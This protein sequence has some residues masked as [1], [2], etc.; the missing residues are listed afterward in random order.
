MK[1]LGLLTHW[2]AARRVSVPLV[3]VRTPDP[4][5]SMAAL[6]SVFNGAPPPLLLWDICGGMRGINDPG[7]EA[8]QAVLPPADESFGGDTGALTAN[9]V[10]ALILAGKLPE[11]AVLYVL[12]AQRILDSPSVI[13]A[14]WNLRDQFKGNR[15]TLVMLGPDFT[16]PP[17][18]SGDVLTLDEPLPSRDDLLAIVADQTEAAAL[19][20]LESGEPTPAYPLEAGR[21]AVD[22]VAGLAAFPAEQAIAMSLTRKGID[23]AGLWER[24]REMIDQTPGLSVWRGGDSFAD[25]AGYSNVKDFLGRVMGGEEAPKVVVFIDEI[26]KALA[27]SGGQGGDTS[28]VSQGFLG[29]ILT[30]MQDAEASGCIFIGPPGSG[31]SQV[32]KAAGAEGG[33]PTIALDMG[34]MKASLVGESEGRLRQALKVVSAVGQGRAL[35]IATCNSIASLPPELRRRFGFGTFFFD[36]PTHD[37]R[38]AIWGLYIKR[39]KIELAGGR[40]PVDAGWTGA[41]IKQCCQLAYRLRCSLKEAA[42]YIVPVSKSAGQQI[43]QLRQQA[44][45]RFISASEPGTYEYRDNSTAATAATGSRSLEVV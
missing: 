21:Q 42:R 31:K 35:F 6:G 19:P 12:N 20:L 45:G 36:L 18:L 30:Y 34:G 29:C 1:L 17:E 8:M 16:L 23:I 24:K 32:A 38:T 4:Q 27:G 5:A 43:K 9:P 25:V 15:R 7:R 13:Q 40:L 37:E 3:A 39:Y 44:S 41:E 2:R 11:G 28:G 14:I 26:E 33:I 22:A 10:E